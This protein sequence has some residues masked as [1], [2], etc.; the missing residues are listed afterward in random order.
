MPRSD[1]FAQK[2]FLNRRLALVD[3]L[4]LSWIDVNADNLETALGKRGRHARTQFAESEDRD[5]FNRFHAMNLEVKE[6]SR[7][8]KAEHCN[9]AARP[10]QSYSGRSL[11]EWS[12]IGPFCAFPGEAALAN[13]AETR[14]R[15]LPLQS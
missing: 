5:G 1:G 4:D 9:K 15:P 12:N 2:R 14:S 3:L 8:V 6:D 10:A 7:G 11:N 13:D